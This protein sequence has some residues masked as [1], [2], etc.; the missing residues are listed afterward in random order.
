MK[1]E[2]KKGGKVVLPVAWRHEENRK[3]Y[4]RIGGCHVQYIG[5]SRLARARSHEARSSTAHHIL[6][7]TFR[8]ISLPA[9]FLSKFEA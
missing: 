4:G 3:V 1:G 5:G 2:G 7:R 9:G 6:V 8:F